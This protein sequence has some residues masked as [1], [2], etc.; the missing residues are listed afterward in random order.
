MKLVTDNAFSKAWKKDCPTC[1][2]I[3]KNTILWFKDQCSDCKKQY[4]FTLKEVLKAIDLATQVYQTKDGK[5]VY[6]GAMN[7]QTII[8]TLV[9]EKSKT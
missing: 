3:E 5:I 8:D 4:T 9:N 1:T 7:A 6:A 2:K